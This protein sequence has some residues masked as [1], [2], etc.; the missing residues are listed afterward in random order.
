MDYY[1]KKSIVKNYK[2]KYD[3]IIEYINDKNYTVVSPFDNNKDLNKTIKQIMKEVEEFEAK[4]NI[5]ILNLK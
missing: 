5:N 4:E 1:S 3:T 2:G